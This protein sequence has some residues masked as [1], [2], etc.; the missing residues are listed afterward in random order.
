MWI[1]NYRL[2]WK[3]GVPVVLPRHPKTVLP[4]NARTKSAMELF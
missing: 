2:I 1:G 4:R 3:D